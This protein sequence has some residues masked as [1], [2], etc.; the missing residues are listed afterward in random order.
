[1]E[2]DLNRKKFGKRFS[3][4]LWALL[5]KLLQKGLIAESQQ[6]SEWLDPDTAGAAEKGV[7]HRDLRR[8]E[9]DPPADSNELQNNSKPASGVGREGEKHMK[10][11]LVEDNHRGKDTDYQDAIVDPKRCIRRLWFKLHKEVP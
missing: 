5:K 6:Q 2:G 11:I 1:L 10:V 7:R 4:V 3:D 8:F 9:R